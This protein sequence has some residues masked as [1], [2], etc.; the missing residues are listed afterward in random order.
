MKYWIIGLVLALV[1]LLEKTIWSYPLTLLTLLALSF[2]LELRLSLFLAFVS[3]LFLDL[4]SANFWGL[5]SALLIFLVFSFAFYR[6]FWH[7]RGRVGQIFIHYLFLVPFVATASYFYFVVQR[8]IGV[9]RVVFDLVPSFLIASA[10]LFL[11]LY[12][13]VYFSI[14]S[15]EP[16]KQLP[17]DLDSR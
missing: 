12:P 17:L 3:G 10:I 15:Q 11:A 13:V 4:F 9:G 14:A 7:F 6:S 1:A 8:S 16:K 5:S 2:F